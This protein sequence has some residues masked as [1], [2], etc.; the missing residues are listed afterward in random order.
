M[1]GATPSWHKYCGP[2]SH[3]PVDSVA[4]QSHIHR[5]HV[6]LTG[7]LLSILFSNF[8]ACHIMWNELQA[9]GGP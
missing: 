1:A 5:V 9:L 7:S 8:I 3:A 6:C 2:Y 4:I